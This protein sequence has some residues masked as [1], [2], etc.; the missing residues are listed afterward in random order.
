MPASQIQA[1]VIKPRNYEALFYGLTVG[2]DPDPYAFWHSSQAYEDGFNMAN[3]KN[4]EV[5]QL[6]EDARLISNQDER[7]AKYVK[8]QEII[9]DEIP[10]IFMYSPIYTYI[11][12]NKIKGFDVSN[13]LFPS[14]R[15]SNIEEWYLK[16]GQK[17]V[18]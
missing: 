14:D 1:E 8:F 16:T 2:A 12:K 17:L 7:K 11:Q 5:D 15:F 9:T 13:I 18:W 4:S 6:L 3:F 10:A